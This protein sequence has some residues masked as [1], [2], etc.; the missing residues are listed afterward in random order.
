MAEGKK[1]FL[2]LLLLLQKKG[3][4]SHSRIRSK[5]E[6]STKKKRNEMLVWSVLALMMIDD[7]GDFVHFGLEHF[8]PK[9]HFFSSS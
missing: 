3:V 1:A 2:V 9:V 4:H 8:G 7:G 5:T 6:C